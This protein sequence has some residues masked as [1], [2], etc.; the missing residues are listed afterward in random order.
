MTGSGAIDWEALRAR[1]ASRFGSGWEMEPASVLQAVAAHRDYWKPD[2]VRVLLLAESHVWTDAAELAAKVPLATYGHAKAPEEFVRLVYCLGYGEDGLL[3]RSV[4]GNAGTWQFWK[5]LAAC[6]GDPQDAKVLKG[7]ERNLTRR[8]GAK[9]ALL[10]ELKARGVWLLDASPVALY[11]QGGSKPKL[12]PQALRIA[13]EEYSGTVVQAVAPRAVMVIGKMVHNVL[14]EH[15]ETAVAAGVSVEWMYQPQARVSAEK[16][17]DGIRRLRDMV[18]RYGRKPEWSGT[19][20]TE[21]RQ[22]AT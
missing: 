3:S 22:G 4:S 1:L 18:E 14:G 17:A 6:V 9:I 21:R 12:L 10:A 11:V 13:W 8:V 15:I 16:H 2:E 19:R 5:L 7:A 20:E